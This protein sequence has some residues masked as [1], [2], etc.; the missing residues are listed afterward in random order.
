MPRRPKRK[1]RAKPAAQRLWDVLFAAF[2]LQRRNKKITL[3]SVAYNS[4][5]DLS[6]NGHTQGFLTKL[7]EWGHLRAIK[8]THWNG[9]RMTMYRL[10]LLG[11]K[12]G[13]PAAYE[14][15]CQKFGRDRVEELTER[16]RLAAATVK[17]NMQDG[18]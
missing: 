1:P 4:Y 18:T 13:D 15:L 14:G 6:P 12:D 17:E 11:I 16:Q 3:T 2:D 8:T 5:V 7:V 9:V 10:D